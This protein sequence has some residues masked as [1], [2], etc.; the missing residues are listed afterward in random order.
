MS[1]EPYPSIELRGF[2]VCKHVFC[3][4]ERWW[5]LLGAQAAWKQDAA[6]LRRHRCLPV[7][8]RRHFSLPPAPDALQCLHRR[9]T[10]WLQQANL[11]VDTAQSRGWVCR[12]DDHYIG[13]VGKG[14]VTVYASNS[15]HLITCFRP[16]TAEMKAPA[17]GAPHAHSFAAI[18]RAAVRRLRR[19]A[20]LV[21]EPRPPRPTLEGSP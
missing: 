10:E 12:Q 16:L 18:E 20:S 6:L 9:H 21:G 14:G 19:R 5:E 13:F 7:P 15:H 3:D 4:D 17:T 2:K 8:R 11:A 1:L